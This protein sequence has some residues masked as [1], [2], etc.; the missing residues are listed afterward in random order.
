MSRKRRTW[1]FLSKCT[2]VPS[3]TNTSPSKFTIRVLTLIP[4]FVLHWSANFCIFIFIVSR[5]DCLNSLKRKAC[6][7]EIMIK[8]SNLATWVHWSYCA[9][10]FASAHAWK[11]KFWNFANENLPNIAC[12]KF[13]H[14]VFQC[15][16]PP[17]STGTS[18]TWKRIVRKFS[19]Q[20]V[21]RTQIQCDV[22][23]SHAISPAMITKIC[24]PATIF[25][26]VK[27]HFFILRWF[28]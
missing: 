19:L 27:S 7:K 20:N 18:S 23:A 16:F 3:R 5:N 21:I 10:P 13:V 8:L 1:E 4:L 15:F 26:L 2:S 17:H 11:L 25:H 28:I 12:F 22:F 24:I 6:I 9:L 14:Q